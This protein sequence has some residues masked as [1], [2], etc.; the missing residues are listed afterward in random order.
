MST[1]I[2]APAILEETRQQMLYPLV[3]ARLDRVLV[4]TGQ[5]VDAGDPLFEFTDPELALK[6]RQSHT[7]IA[8]YEARE[9]SSAGDAVELA[10]RLIVGRLLDQEREALSALE[11]RERRLTVRATQS[12]IVRELSPSLTPN[13]WFS[14]KNVLGRIVEPGEQVVSGF[15]SEADRDLLDLSKIGK[16]I[17]DD[18]EVPAVPLNATELS[19]FSVDRLPDGYLSS[20][21]GGAI[22]V[23]SAGS[24]D[25]VP[26]AAWYPFTATVAAEPLDH[27]AVQRGVVVL[28]RTPE[29]LVKRVGRQ[30]AKVLIRESG[31]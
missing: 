20:P 26:L 31:F 28:Y 9:T 7:R 3:D 10:D 27:D 5:H 22:P 30:I 21:N 19:D 8:M 12:G 23:A 2:K 24:S 29:S 16:F 17:A 4:E 6:I 11:D 14:R 1:R 13:R 25:L 15:I 18:I